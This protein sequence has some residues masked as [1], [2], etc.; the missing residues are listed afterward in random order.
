[1]R[2]GALASDPDAAVGV[3]AATG[4][5][6]GGERTARLLEEHGRPFGEHG[7]PFGEGG[8][9]AEGGLWD[10]ARAGR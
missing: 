5:S 8:G 7:G 6:E 10:A 4:L 2:I 9:F 1:V 3:P